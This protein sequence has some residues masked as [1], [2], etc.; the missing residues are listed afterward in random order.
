MKKLAVAIWA[1][2]LKVRSSKILFITLG[3]FVFIPLMMGLMVYI[4][5]NPSIS[6]KLGLIAAKASLFGNADG[7]GF[8]NL[9]NQLIATVGLIGFG[10]VTAWVFGREYLEKTMKDIL[11][12]PVSRTYIVLAKCVVVAL[13]C[14]ALMT[15]MYASAV[16]VGLV[17]EL[18]GWTLQLITSGVI[19][20]Y[21]TGLMTILLCT[22]VAFM[23]GY[24]RGL[25]AA[26]GFVII[27][28]IAGQFIAVGGLGAF[29][30]WAVPGLYTVPPDTPGMQLYPI[31]YILLFATSLLGL[32]ATLY[33]WKNADH[34]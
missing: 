8:L 34:Y 5:R 1:E 31:S 33:W 27:T 30:P 17:I 23:A 10:F 25:M 11:A 14:L 4:I 26:L 3:L 22:P 21:I 16:I 19:K 12:L 29:F 20:F 24:G 9:I 7:I 6:A 2:Y 32:T 15:V 28:L 13:W 18:E